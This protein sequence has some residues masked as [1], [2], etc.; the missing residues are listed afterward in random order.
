[1]KQA[2]SGDTGVIA[3]E[4]THNTQNNIVS[5]GLILLINICL[6]R[7]TNVELKMSERREFF[8]IPSIAMDCENQNA[9]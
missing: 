1:M 2:M 3:E 5:A 8:W 9:S 6:F 7:R 4:L